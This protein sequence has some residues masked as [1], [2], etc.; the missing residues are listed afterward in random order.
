MNLKLFY[1]IT[2][3]L[4]NSKKIKLF[5]FDIDGVMTD[6]KL[7]FDD[8]G[9]ET[10]FFNTLDGMGVVMALKA[11]IKIAVITGSKAS[12]VKKRFDK[13][14]V[15]G[16]EDLIQGE[17]YKMPALLTLIEKY[18]LKNEEVAYMGDDVIDL[19]PSKYVGFSFAPKNAIKEVKKN[20]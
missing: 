4:K 3:I 1:P 6:G 13:F 2:L 11:G 16:F 18:G 12:C 19:A 8:N 9:V 20:C 10:K 5:V 15:H 17:E 14:R 7:I